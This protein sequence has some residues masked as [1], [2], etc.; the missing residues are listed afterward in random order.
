[1]R[2]VLEA[3]EAV[4]GE[5]DEFGSRTE[6]IGNAELPAGT[7]WQATDCHIIHVHFYSDRPAGWKALGRDVAQGTRPCT[8]NECDTCLDG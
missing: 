2:K 5:F 1:M 3:I 7:V 6:L 4:G 8:D